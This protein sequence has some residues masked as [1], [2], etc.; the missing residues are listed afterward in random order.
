MDEANHA[1]N[2]VRKI[3]HYKY[4]KVLHSERDITRINVVCSGVFVSLLQ[5][6]KL[7][8]VAYLRPNDRTIE[9]HEYK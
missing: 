4:A 5:L 2:P 1:R 8:Q 7:K 6:P 9:A 3:Q